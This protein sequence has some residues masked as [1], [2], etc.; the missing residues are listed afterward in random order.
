MVRIILPDNRTLLSLMDSGA[1]KSVISLGCIKN[2]DY[3][4][5]L[6]P[7]PCKPTQFMVGN[8]GILKSDT[9]LTFKFVLQGNIFELSAHVVDT[10]GGVDLIIGTKSL[11][12][13]RSILDFTDN[14]LHFKRHTILA[15]PSVHKTIDPGVTD[16]LPIKATLPKFLAHSEIYLKIGKSLKTMTPTVVLI[17]FNNNNSSILV[18]NPS[19]T[20]YH[21]HPNRSIGIISLSNLGDSGCVIQPFQQLNTVTASCGMV[22]DPLSSDPSIIFNYKKARY[23]H[24]DDDDW[25]LR[26]TDVCILKRETDFCDDN[27]PLLISQKFWAL[28]TSRTEAYSLHDDIG[29]VKNSS[30]KIELTDLSPFFVRPYSVNARQRESIQKEL[31]KLVKLGIIAPGRG[32]YTCPVILI[33]K[34]ASGNSKASARIVGDFREIN[35]RIKPLNYAA[36]LLRDALSIIGAS[37]ASV[38]THLDVK[39]AFHSFRLD[40]SSRKYVNIIGYPSGPSYQY[41]RLGQGLNVSPSEYQTAMSEIMENIPEYNKNIICVADDI[42]IFSKNFDDHLLHLEHLLDTMIAHGLKIS[43]N[44]CHYFKTIVDYLGHTLAIRDGCPTIT[45]QKSK[46]EAIMKLDPPKNPSDMRSIIGMITFLA[47]YIPKLQLLLKPLHPLSSKSA[48]FKWTNEH[49]AAFDEIKSLLQ[50]ETVLSLPSSRGLYRLYCDSSYIGTGSMLCQ[51]QH[52]VEKILGFYS[53][54]FTEAAR[55]YSVTETEYHGIT[56]NVEAFK[57]ILRGHFFEIYTDHSSIVHLNKSKHEL[58]SLRLRKSYLKLSDYNFEIKYMKGKDLVVPDFLSRNPTTDIADNS[59]IAFTHLTPHIDG[60]LPIMT[61]SATQASGATVLPGLLPNKRSQRRARATASPRPSSPSDISTP[62]R[63]TQHAP[64]RD[65]FVPHRSTLPYDPQ[66]TSI[67]QPFPQTERSSLINPN[68]TDLN[69]TYRDFLP[70]YVPEPEEILI[71]KPDEELFN[72][73]RPIFNKDDHVDWYHRHIPKGKDLERELA[74]LNSRYLTDYYLPVSKQKLAGEQSTDPFLRPVYAFVKDGII[75]GNKQSQRKLIALSEGFVMADNILFK[76]DLKTNDSMLHTRLCI[77]DSY[78]SLIFNIYHDSL[79]GDHL[80][81]SKTF[82]NIRSKFFIRNLYTR[83]YDY[84]RSCHICQTLK[85]P[86]DTDIPAVQRIHTNYSP[87]SEISADIKY[88]IEGTHGYKFFFLASC[89]ITRYV[90]GV[91]LRKADAPSVA[92]AILKIVFTFGPPRLIIIDKDSAFTNSLTKLVYDALRIKTTTVSPF[93]HSS[94]LVERHI[95]TISRLLTS[96]LSRAGRSWP[97]LLPSAVYAYNTSPLLN[98]GMSPHYLVFLRNPPTISDLEFNPISDVARNLQDYAKILKY[99][100]NE[101]SKF[102]LDVHTKSQLERQARMALRINKPYK[103]A[104][105]SVCYLLAPSLTTLLTSSRKITGHYIGPLFVRSLAGDSKYLLMDTRGRHIHGVYHLSR[106]KPGF[107]RAGGKCISNLEDL[108]KE[109]NIKDFDKLATNADIFKQTYNEFTVPKRI[110]HLQSMLILAPMPHID[111]PL[112]NVFCESPS[113]S[114][115]NTVYLNCS[116]DTI[117]ADTAITL[118]IKE[119]RYKNGSL[120]LLFCADSPDL[121]IQ[122]HWTNLETHPPLSHF[123]ESVIRDP[124]IRKTGS[125]RKFMTNIAYPCR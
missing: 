113:K 108:K 118:Y 15:Y 103:L 5:K 90:M 95:G 97:L 106:L 25:R 7:I 48:S 102:I 104:V 13:L 58:P 28:L 36:P 115:H 54:R 43:P 84:L 37:E 116:G 63:A 18:H 91:P 30:I 76:L 87:M 44:K 67:K 24:L 93:H 61:R 77:P 33:Q 39:S 52:G 59:H 124:R 55:S 1:T 123:L 82:L 4:S 11:A 120:E 74:E 17:T 60:L 27:I 49:Q 86:H 50:R 110:D 23:P 45:A 122:N 31:N 46:I 66:S 117:N 75:S 29:D 100:L 2:C 114:V 19:N 83:L 70:Q 9:I 121:C 38:F 20:P 62:E 6:G 8:G 53:K 69:D 88:M 16:R 85:H 56:L 94:L 89:N 105:G 107:I 72:R 57:Y 99:K 35:K 64:H 78:I 47:M 71:N 65:D 125:M 51:V 32:S 109:I 42:L 111:T 80:G 14:T 101:V 3:L 73:P 92:D 68:A 112:S 98:V 41:L 119:A 22:P 96:T 40:E 10:L 21:F 81:V 26:S 34:V 12:E 79:L